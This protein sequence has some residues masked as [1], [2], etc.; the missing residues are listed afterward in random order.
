MKLRGTIGVRRG[1]VG[2]SRQ[3][4]KDMAAEV[5]RGH[6][7]LV[8]PEGTRTRTGRVGT[9]RKGVFFLARDLGVPIVPVAVTGMYE[10]MRKGSW[11]LRPGYTVTVHVM[12]PVPTA[13]LTDP[14][15]LEVVQQ[16]QDR[17]S[18]KVDAYW[19][20]KSRRTL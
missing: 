9:C 15:V 16:V 7:L 14:Q 2:G 17:L 10:T 5:E 18:D 1:L 8:F 3:L 4:L 13:G 6:S 12:A 19:R 11:I 20:D